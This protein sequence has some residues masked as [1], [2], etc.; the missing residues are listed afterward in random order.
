MVRVSKLQLFPVFRRHLDF[1]NSTFYPFWTRGREVD[2]MLSV[3]VSVG[4][5]SASEPYKIREC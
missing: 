1:S 5:S 4:I 2:R 3:E